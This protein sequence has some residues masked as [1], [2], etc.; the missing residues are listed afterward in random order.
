MAPISILTHFADLHKENVSISS[1]SG[2]DHLTADGDSVGDLRQ[3]GGFELRR[4]T[5]KIIFPPKHPCGCDSPE[6]ISP[7]AADHRMA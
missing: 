1:L 7:E 5:V 4:S 2:Q 6:G 3:P